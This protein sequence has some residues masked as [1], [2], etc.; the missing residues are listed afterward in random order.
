MYEKKRRRIS[1][2]N[3]PKVGDAPHAI[4]V[5]SA[6]ITIEVLEQPML[7]ICQPASLKKKQPQTVNQ[8][9]LINQILLKKSR[10][11]YSPERSCTGFGYMLAS[12]V[13]LFCPNKN[14]TPR[15]LMARL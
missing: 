2:T 11:N 7:V 3:S 5:S 15:S 4:N 9:F 14:N 12:P 10:K 8:K 6:D 13:F 1:L